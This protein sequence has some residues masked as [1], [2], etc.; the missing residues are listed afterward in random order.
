MKQLCHDTQ[1]LC[2]KY[3]G[4]VDN[5]ASLQSEDIFEGKLK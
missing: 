5:D 2:S 3:Q 1:L 4:K